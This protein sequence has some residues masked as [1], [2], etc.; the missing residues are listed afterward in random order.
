MSM[1]PDEA[2]PVW[3]VK[4]RDYE[5]HSA[6]EYR[7]YI[8]ELLGTRERRWHILTPQNRWLSKAEFGDLTAALR[9][10]DSL[11]EA[12]SSGVAARLEKM[13]RDLA[14]RNQGLAREPPPG[15][16]CAQCMA[17]AYMR[18]DTSIYL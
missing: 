5:N 14:E 11:L 15:C 18:G 16:S 9:F 13:G 17:A 7:G 2:A 3:V 12:Q 4:V 6:V 10:I 1:T 8:A